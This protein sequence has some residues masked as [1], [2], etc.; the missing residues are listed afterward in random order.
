MIIARFETEQAAQVKLSEYNALAQSP[1]PQFNLT[2]IRKHT[3][4]DVW[5]F[6]ASDCIDNGGAGKEQI[7]QDI[8]TLDTITVSSYQ[9]LI[10]LGY[11]PEP[12]PPPACVNPNL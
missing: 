8:Q 9:E 12:T 11:L 4:L 6:N 1:D 2:T 10:Q 7:E 3:T 5:W